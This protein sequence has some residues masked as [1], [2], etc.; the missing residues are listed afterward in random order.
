MRVP[1]HRRVLQVALRLSGLLLLAPLA[2]A[3]SADMDSP[4][5][6]ATSPEH[7]FQLVR[8]AYSEARTFSF[9]RR[10]WLIDAPEAEVH[11]LDGVQRLARID[12]SGYSVALAPL[13]DR[14]FDYPFLYAVEVGH[15]SLSDAEAQRL[16]EYLLRGG[17]LVVDDFWGTREWAVFQDSLRRIFPD[18]PVVELDAS[19]P[20]FHVL[21]DVTERPQIPSIYGAVTGRTWEQDGYVPHWR[22]VLDDEGRVMIAIHFNMDMGDA[23]EHADNPQYPAELTLLAYRYGIDEILYAMTH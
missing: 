9:R 21:Y 17:F 8:L 13:D 11:F 22:G 19:H 14:L 15:W 20:L 10:S 12:T 2:L 4:R 5:E 3:L 1:H 6:P 16:R 18:R 23:W 7:E